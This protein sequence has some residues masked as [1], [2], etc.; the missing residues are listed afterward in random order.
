L[1]NG[2]L[3]KCH[4]RYGVQAAIERG[5]WLQAIL[6]NAIIVHLR[7]PEDARRI[8]NRAFYLDSLRRDQW[9]EEEWEKRGF[10]I[11]KFHHFPFELTKKGRAERLE[12]LK[13]RFTELSKQAKKQAREGNG[14]FIVDK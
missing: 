8:K 7:E 6:S 12:M 1:I 14:Q 11:R 3:I 13:E 10:D 2:T 9:T 5:A 4:P